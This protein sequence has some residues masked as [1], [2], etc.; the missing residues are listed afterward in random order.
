MMKT[1]RSFGNQLAFTLVELV[2]AVAIISVV[3]ISYVGANI[4][5]QRNTEDMHERTIAIQDANRLIERMRS[6]SRTVTLFPE[7]LITDYPENTPIT[8]LDEATHQEKPVFSNLP[9]ER[10]VI[11]YDI[12]NE[13]LLDT[14]VTI[15]W[16]S[17]TGR[18]Y[19]EAVR[20]YITQR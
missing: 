19:S 5:L 10:A 12:P 14:I 9:N 20:T 8:E 6:D 1:K 15:T 7:G 13:N 4:M 17:Y 2:I 18:T 16:T 3:V 11:T